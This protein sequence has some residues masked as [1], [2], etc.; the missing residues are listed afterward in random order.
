MHQTKAQRYLRRLIWLIG[1]IL[2]ITIGFAWWFYP[3][4]YDFFNETISKLGGIES[5]S[6]LTNTLS[7][8]IFAAGFGV[9]AL[10]ALIMF[11]YYTTT[12]DITEKYLKALWCLLISI[13]AIGVALPVD[14]PN[15]IYPHYLGALIFVLFFGVFNFETQAARFL[16]KRKV[17]KQL[18]HQKHSFDFWIDLTFVFIVFIATGVFITVFIIERIWLQVPFIST[19]LTQKILLIV[20]IIAI[21]LLDVDDM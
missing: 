2:I 20:N 10:I 7:S 14:I 18:L 1:L 12:K 9:I 13:G 17:R 16:R 15:L 8:L 3:E 21:Y 6:G 5:K 4:N 19:A 11:F